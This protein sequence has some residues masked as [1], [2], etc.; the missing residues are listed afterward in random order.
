MGITRTGHGDPSIAHG[1][2]E[3]EACRQAAIIRAEGGYVCFAAIMAR[4][5]THNQDILWNVL[6]TIA[7]NGGL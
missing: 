1:L 4:M 2:Y 6:W 5:P 7:R 3:V